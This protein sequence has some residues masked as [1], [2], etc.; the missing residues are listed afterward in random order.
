[1][2]RELI[3]DEFNCAS[4][5]YKV[6]FEIENPESP[7]LIVNR[8][9]RDWTP[10]PDGNVLHWQPYT[11]GSAVFIEIS[12]MRVNGDAILNGEW[13]TNTVI[14]KRYKLAVSYLGVSGQ[15]NAVINC[16]VGGQL[17]ASTIVKNT[18]LEFVFTA[19]NSNDFIYLTSTSDF[20]VNQISLI[21]V[22]TGK[23][24]S[25]GSVK[26]GNDSKNDWLLYPGVIELSIKVLADNISSHLK[27]IDKWH[28]IDRILSSYPS[29]ITL[30]HWEDNE[31][32]LWLRTTIDKDDIGTNGKEKVFKL[33]TLDN[34]QNLGLDRYVNPNPNNHAYSFIK[35]STI[36]QFL[37]DGAADTL[38]YDF[39]CKW[40]FRDINDTADYT[41]DDIYVNE[42][43]FYYGKDYSGLGYPAGVPYITRADILKSIM[44]N[45]ASVFI[46]GF[47]GMHIMMPIE[48]DGSEP[49]ILY[50][51]ELTAPEKYDLPKEIGFNDYL[52]T[53]LG[54]WALG[55][56]Y[57][58]H[59]VNRGM[60]SN[61]TWVGDNGVVRGDG[62]IDADFMITLT[63]NSYVGNFVAG[64]TY[65][66]SVDVQILSGG[67]TFRV[68]INSIQVGPDITAV[69]KYV[70]TFTAPSNGNS[71]KMGTLNTELFRVGTVS[72]QDGNI[73]NYFTPLM[74]ENADY[75]DLFFPF[76][77][78]YGSSGYAHPTLAADESGANPVKLNA[79]KIMD[80]T[81][82][83]TAQDSMYNHAKTILKRQ[84]LNS[85]S[86][87]IV[88]AKGVDLP[89]NKFY[90]IRFSRTNPVPVFGGVFRCK[91]YLISPETN[92]TSLWLV[93]C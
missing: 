61:S 69:G 93:E 5:K 23:I 21:A 38:S 67:Q 60:K 86:G 50:L 75:S 55:K 25:L 12:R 9:D 80:R 57:I 92:R 48:Y 10:I 91:Q 24:V 36:I 54:Y 4:G 89:Q 85:R 18:L 73:E 62:Y 35:L 11:A 33:R 37:V 16:T 15:P 41:L 19:A 51:N 64:N 8:Y 30:Y 45:L 3:L 32:A 7:D 46:R 17:V 29:Y 14:G 70:F 56:D 53:D 74:D 65:T 79:V 78:D 44:H 76:P 43:A 66:I 28:Y 72:I 87:L 84:L 31:W 59:N 83:Y 26:I 2:S 52:H 68:Y 82:N 90:E 71:V 34:V 1:M 20:Y 47:R 77:V 6:K 40:L 58:L 81:G 22:E 42:I 13:F 27:E 63:G 88:K 49:H 39:V